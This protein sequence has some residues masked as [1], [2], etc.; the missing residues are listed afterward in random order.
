M[1][2]TGTA[3]AV[4][5]STGAGLATNSNRPL[6]SVPNFIAPY[7]LSEA[8]AL[9]RVCAALGGIDPSTLSVS[10][11]NLFSNCTAIIGTHGGGVDAAGL[12]TFNA[13]SGMQSTAQQRVG[14]QFAGAQ[15]T[16]IGTRLMQLR[17]DL[18]GSSLSGLDLGL[19]GGNGLGQLFAALGDATG[20]RSDSGSP[21]GT[22]SS[23]SSAGGGA[24][25][26]T[27]GSSSRLG[28]FINGSVRRGSQDPTTYETPFDF[29][30]TSITAGVDYRLTD[31]WIIGG[32]LGH[33]SGTTEFTDGTGR[34]DSHSNLISLYGTYYQDAFYVDL[35]GTYGHI[36]YDA[37]RTTTFTINLN[38][39]DVPTNCMEGHSARSTPTGQP[40]RSNSHSAAT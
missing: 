26:A 20:R 35:I 12:R 7:Q 25:D 15:F 3:V 1:A 33:S 16:N 31:R 37:T 6:T 13:I 30:A 10:Q 29:K 36:S 21:A 18:R 11:R 23:S 9:E 38:T 14:V 39:P 5:V 40:A 34:L 17:Q 2:A 32:A 4:H 24:G 8:A 27:L 28:F 22:D 19:P